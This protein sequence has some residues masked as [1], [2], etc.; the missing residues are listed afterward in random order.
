MHTCFFQLYKSKYNCNILF[1]LGVPCH[2]I[3]KYI[4]AETTEILIHCFVTSK[5]DFCNALL[6]GLPQ[7]QINKLQNVQNAAARLI[8]RL[9]KY[10]HISQTLKDLHWL[11]VEQRIVFKI[12]LTHKV[13]NGTAPHYLQELLNRYEPLRRL[14]SSSDKWRFAIRRYNQE[15]YGRRAFAIMAPKL[16]NKLPLEL[17]SISKSNIFKSS[18]KT[19]PLKLAYDL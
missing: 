13:L 5:L 14:R 6:Y 19:Y 2:Q 17:R 9:R 8:A 3:R 16:W 10:D 11:P 12:N 4:S 18:L 1:F 15:T 7:Y